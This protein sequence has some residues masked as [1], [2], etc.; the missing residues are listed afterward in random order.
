MIQK[1]KHMY[2]LQPEVWFIKKGKSESTGFRSSSSQT[3]N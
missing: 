1:L 2:Q 3:S